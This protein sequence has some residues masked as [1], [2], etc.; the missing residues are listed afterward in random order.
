MPPIGGRN[1]AQ[2]NQN[3]SSRNSI[4]LRNKGGIKPLHVSCYIQATRSDEEG[5]ESSNCRVT[6]AGT[7]FYHIYTDISFTIQMDPDKRQHI[8]S[9]QR[10]ILSRR[11]LASYFTAVCISCL[12]FV[13]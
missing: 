5:I 3:A 4:Y 1:I 13:S 2:L 12:H 9:N 11:C 7:A 10:F 8:L 6:L